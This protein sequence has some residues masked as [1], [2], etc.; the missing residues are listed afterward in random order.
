MH[1][2]INYS[3][4]I[5]LSESGKCGK[6]DEKIIK[7]WISRERKELFRWNKKI[8]TV[9]EGQSFGGKKKDKIAGTSFKFPQNFQTRLKSNFLFT[10]ISIIYFKMFFK[11]T[12]VKLAIGR[13]SLISIYWF[14]STNRFIN[15]HLFMHSHKGG[16]NMDLMIKPPLWECINKLENYI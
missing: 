16:L 13:L 14:Q 4:P 8:F 1:G 2:I 9:F 5:F 6:E 3:T 11:T 10:P 15:S 7:I 12:G